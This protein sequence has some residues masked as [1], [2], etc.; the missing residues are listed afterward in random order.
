MVGKFGSLLILLVRLEFFNKYLNL[1]LLFNLE[2]D[3]DNEFCF[4]LLLSD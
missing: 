2:N 3:N 4:K 1:S